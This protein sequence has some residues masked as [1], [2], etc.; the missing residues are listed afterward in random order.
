MVCII[1]LHSEFLKEMQDMLG[2]EF[3]AFVES[4]NLP[5]KRG[6]RINTLKF[7][8][9]NRELLNLPLSECEFASSGFYLNTEDGGI[10]NSPW[11][12]AGAFYSQEPSAMSAVTVL[13]PQP[14]EKILDMCSAPGGKSTQIAAALKGNGL[15]WS[16][17]YVR[18]RAQI[19]LS[20]VERMGIRN[21]V[22]SN[23]HPDLLASKLC[24]F[25]DR[26][27]VDAPCSGEGMFRRDSV[28]VAEWTPEHS[29]TC[30]VRQ[31]AILESAAECVSSGGVMV[32]STCTFSFC[33]N[34]DVVIAFLEKHPEFSIIDSG[35]S[36]GRAGFNRSDKF[37]LTL[38]RR[39]FPMDGG[40][41]HFV[42]KMKKSGESERV[43]YSSKPS[44][45]TEGE[46]SAAD[47]FEQCFLCEPYGKI[48]QIGESCYILPQDMLDTR[49]L[50]V[51]RGG[52]LLGDIMR[53]RIEPSHALFMAAAAEDCKRVISLAPDSPELA[54]FLKGE[55]ISAPDDFKG[56]TAV[57]CGDTITGFGKCSG[58]RLKN[59]YPKGL[60]MM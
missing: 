35:V 19:L 38:S 7:D 41:G 6:I 1:Q 56:Y 46:K 55:E 8:V 4:Y 9:N 24:G 16:N 47:L 59:R 20:N 21:C 43:S 15:L 33:E 18:K 2:N 42:A 52:V 57:A 13:G 10:G 3:D 51:L 31:L 48:T 29:A 49:G 26:V 32:Y 28:A 22:V 17:E 53:N 60:R 54:A 30:A 27:L 58:G 34:E 37:D 25:F 12:H 50:G 40:E 5:H 44:K 39:I 23:A 11:H 36:F 14:G 45:P